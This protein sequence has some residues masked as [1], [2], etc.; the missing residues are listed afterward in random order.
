M[1]NY[2]RYAIEQTLSLLAIDSPSGYTSRAAEWVRDAFTALGFEAHLTVKGGVLADL[3]GTDLDNALL[4]EAHT[5]TLG[6][7]VAEIKSD[8]RLRVTPLGGMCAE[9]GE[10]ENVR[11]YTANEVWKEDRKLFDP[12][13][14]V[15][16]VEQLMK[17]RQT[18]SFSFRV[19]R[20]NALIYYQCQLVRLN[21]KNREYLIAFKNI[22]EEKKLELAQQRRIEEALLA[23]EN[24]N[25][26][27][28]EESLVSSALSLE[29][30]S[31]FEIDPARK[32]VSLY[33]TDGKSL[34]AS[35]LQKL[36]DLKDY[37]TAI[38]AYIVYTG[39]SIPVF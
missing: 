24:V 7:M 17:D 2:T 23:V 4:L 20:N 9:N 14:D 31:I 25:A 16:S 15:A 30:C 39:S 8:G 37:E 10:A 22:D 3:G 35:A 1:Q 36:L 26:S 27:L 28:R 29:Y 12:I 32:E 19:F 5:D 34:P 11:V 13:A 6:A 38:Q 33:R 18:C 21:P